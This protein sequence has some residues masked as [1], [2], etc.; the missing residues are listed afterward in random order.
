MGFGYDLAESAVIL[1]QAGHRWE[2]VR[3]MTIRQIDAWRELIERQRIAQRAQI[4]SIMRAA[5]GA[6]KSEY[7]KYLKKL[8]DDS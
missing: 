5:F 2:D 8:T 3:R 4:L 6:N 7:Q 1:I